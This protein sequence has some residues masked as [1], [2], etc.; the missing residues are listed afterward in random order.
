MA[1]TSSAKDISRILTLVAAVVVITALYFARVM[2]VPLALA[3]LFSFVLAPLVTALER[4]RIPRFLAIFLVVGIAVSGI[5]IMG[6]TVG[7]QLID[8]TNQLPSYKTNI[9][10]KI[11]AIRNPKNRRLDKAADAMKELGKEIADNPP[12][13]AE[14]APSS[15]KNSG[16]GKAAAQPQPKTVPVQVFQPVSNPLESLN[17]IITP[18]GSAVIVVVLTIF[19]LAGREDLRNRLIGLVGHGHLNVMTQALDDAGSRV[20]RYL[21]LQLVINACFGVVIGLGLY[22]IGIPNSMLWGVVAGLLRFLPYVGS[23]L[24]AVLPIL[25][26]LAIFPT[27]TGPVATIGLYLIVEILVAN[28]LEPLIYGAHTGISSFAILFAAIFW[29]LIWGPI[30]LLLSTPLTVCLVVLGRHV[31]ALQFLNIMLGDQPVLSPEAH[32]YQRL[33]ASDQAEAKEVLDDYLKTHP[34]EDLYDTVLIPALA[35]AEQDRH[36]DDLEE[37]TEQFICKSTKELLDELGEKSKE[38]AVAEMQKAQSDLAELSAPKIRVEPPSQATNVVCIPARD[39]ADE[40]V[41]IMLS[42]LLERAGYHAQAI[43]IGTTAEM[44]AQVKD[45]APDIVCISALP[46]FA[47]LHARDLYKRV[48]SNVPNARIIVGLWKFSGDPIK[49]AARFNIVGDDKLAI[50]L[51]QTILQVGVF[52]Q[53]ELVPEHAGARAS[54][55]K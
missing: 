25:L 24:A 34:L 35:L 8:V 11:D 22:F 47:L 27:W 43:P 7:N 16:S 13:P 18:L 19:M 45:A 15:S 49:A 50:T 55:S 12:V 40:I 20:S 1:R 28:F 5:G 37:I 3:V 21:V 9:K 41:G 10:E 6:W 44:L 26:S 2:L 30:G 31:P 53:I 46:P 54:E 17:S 23:P 32:Y 51:A 4:I 38:P 36:H 39:E 29:A 48:R 33:L 42:Q 14:T 52:Q